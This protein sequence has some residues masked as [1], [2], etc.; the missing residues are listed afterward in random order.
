MQQPI[1]HSAGRTI[2]LF[3]AAQSRKPQK[4]RKHLRDQ[5][6]L[7]TCCTNSCARGDGLSQAHSHHSLL[8]INQTKL[9]LLKFAPRTCQP[10]YTFTA[11]ASMVSLYYTGSVL[12]QQAS[13]VDGQLFIKQAESATSKRGRLARKDFHRS[14]RVVHELLNTW[15]TI[16]WP[17]ASLCTAQLCNSFPG[18]PSLIFSS[19]NSRE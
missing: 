8:E 6:Y 11:L 16:S 13:L 18:K 17:L 9:P 2:T 10:V 7:V 4:P 12:W 3:H 15:W 1:P 5:G 14:C 19:K